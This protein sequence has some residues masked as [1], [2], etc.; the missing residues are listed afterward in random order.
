M[1]WFADSDFLIGVWC[2][3]FFSC[4]ARGVCD[5]STMRIKTRAYKAKMVFLQN[6][7]DTRWDRLARFRSTFVT[8]E[9]PQQRNCPATLLLLVV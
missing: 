2:W 3:F 8:M 5:L 9:A 4:N 6:W 7:Q 1:L